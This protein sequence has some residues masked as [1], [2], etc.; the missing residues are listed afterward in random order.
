MAKS[1]FMRTASLIFLLSVFTLSCVYGQ[2]KIGDNP[3][4]IDPS[5]VL[6][7]ESSTMALIITRVTTAQMEAIVPSQGALVYNTETACVHYYNGTEWVNLCEG[8]NLNLT[9]DAIINDDS[10]ISIA[11]NPDGGTNLEVLP[12]SLTGNQ[13]ID[14]S[15]FGVD[16][17]NNSIGPDKLADNSVGKFKLSEN[18]VG[19][20]AIDR[21]SLPLSF[22]N[23]DV[24]FLTTGDITTVSND[25][26]NAISIGSDNGAFYDDQPL[27]DDIAQNAAD[28]LADGDTNATNEIQTL[29]LD[30][31]N[32]L[33]ILGANTVVLPTAD[34]SDTKITAGT[35]IDIQGNGT[36][37]MPYVISSTDE[38]DGS[39]S[40][41]LQDLAFDDATNILTIS[42]PATAGNEVDLS[43]LAGGGGNPNDELITASVLTGNTL[44]LTEGGNDFDIDLTGL[45]GGSGSTE[46][47]DGT[48]LTGDGTAGDPFKI[49]PSATEGQFLTTDATGVVWATVNPGGGTTEEADQ[50]TITGIGTNADPFKIEPSATLGQF[51]TT[52]ATGVVWT[53]VNPGGGTTEEA[54]QITITGIGTNA[55]PFKIEPSATVGQFLTTDATGVVWATV[56]PGGGTT[57]EADQTT[58]TGIGT[59]AD[60]FKI[61]PS[62]NTN[63]V[64]TTD[65]S[66][67]VVWASGGGTGTTE[68]ADQATITGDGQAGTEFQ[69]ADQGINTQQLADDAITADKIGGDVAG[70]GLLQNATG[71]LEVDP[72]ALVGDGNISGTGITVGGDTDA[73]LG[74]VTLE[75]ADDAITA[76]KIGGDVAGTGLLQ[77]ATG[78]L[79][80]DPTALVGDGNI[81]GT[82]IAVGG[83]TDALLGDV[84]L[85]IA[86]D[87]ITADKLGNDVAG[88]GLLQNA[89][90][91]LE[92]DPT[93]LVGDGN[94][95]ATGITVGGDTDALLGDVTLEITDDAI[96]ADK[97]GNDVAGAGLLQN[98]AGALEVDPA[99]I[100]GDGNI[101]GTGI[102][103]GG[104]T[105]ALLGDV[106]LEITNDAI[107]ADKIGAD[108]AGTGLVQNAAGA[109]EV[110]PTALVG[111]GNITGTGITVGGDTDALLGDVTLEI[112][113]DAITAD[114]IG[115]DVAGTGLVQNATGALE[116]DPTAIVGDGNITGTGITVSGGAN[117]TLTNVGLSITN[118]A[119][120]TAKILNDNVTPAKIAGGAEGQVLTTTDATGTV[121]WA[122]PSARIIAMGKMRADGGFDNIYP[123][124][125]MSTGS[126]GTYTVDISSLGLDVNNDDYIINA[127]AI[128]TGVESIS[129][130]VINQSSISFTVFITRVRGDSPNTAITLVDSAWFFTITDF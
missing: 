112:T 101:T 79:E 83:D 111:D 107:T 21:D 16:I 110:D 76:D 58:I 126:G 82:G 48:T 125:L 90:G 95:T 89:T 7:L 118:N 98:A 87:A 119:V 41:E 38:V 63:E 25:S 104:D 123:N 53:T 27:I 39:I 97:I 71:A 10:T 70:T 64:L 14:G 46:I 100:V 51:L 120:T 24:P 73:L 49:E 56:N 122:T 124:T 67:N 68:L 128:G 75:I 116:V 8:V 5:A 18:A 127:T 29:S 57:E 113:D 81:T 55:D 94:I 9:A 40:N 1:P 44:T 69:V 117:A 66:G 22:F 17:N 36:S 77:N 31:G 2:V 54:D 33:T 130:K 13:I 72:T 32:E 88:T 96:T 19:P 3:Q 74:D 108:V 106:T 47:V 115:A 80:V 93:T 109:L 45:G 43:G 102:T 4:N 20:F 37:A 65:G 86:D 84:T 129:I 6:E 26:P 52:D 30:N 99:A 78:A 42:T 114:K 15:I 35:N 23:N 34:G 61:E 12:N 103:V 91:A 92:V 59:N 85:E 11:P 60:P 50:T 105:D 28:I 121:A 62:A